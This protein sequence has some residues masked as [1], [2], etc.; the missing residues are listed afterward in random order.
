MK[1]HVERVPRLEQRLA[2]I[3]PPF[4]NRDDL[5]DQFDKL[6]DGAEAILEQ[7]ADAYRDLMNKATL[8]PGRLLAADL[9]LPSR[10]TGKPLGRWDTPVRRDR[11]HRRLMDPRP[12][13]QT[14]RLGPATRP[15][16]CCG[17]G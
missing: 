2:P 7:D 17:G 5:A 15:G 12:P 6:F 4:D 3:Q 11:D 9:L 14:P 8:A 10:P 13:A 1:A 16:R